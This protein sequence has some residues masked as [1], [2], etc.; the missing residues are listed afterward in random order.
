VLSFAEK[1]KQEQRSARVDEL[2]KMVIFTG[3]T[4]NPFNQERL[5]SGSP[6]SC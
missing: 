2:E 6:T 4:I 3:A 5:R 1:L